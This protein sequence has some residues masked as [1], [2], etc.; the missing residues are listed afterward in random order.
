MTPS[1]TLRKDARIRI[2]S[3]RQTAANSNIKSPVT[4]WLTP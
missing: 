3:L 2:V 1:E 4:V